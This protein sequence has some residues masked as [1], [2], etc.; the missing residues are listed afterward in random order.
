MEQCNDNDNATHRTLILYQIRIQRLRPFTPTFSKSAAG[1]K[2]PCQQP[3]STIPRG[4]HVEETPDPFRL[5]DPGS[6]GGS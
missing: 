4:Q 1:S 2:S 6:G 3:F 5:S